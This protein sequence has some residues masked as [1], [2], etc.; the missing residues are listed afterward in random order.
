MSTG[1]RPSIFGRIVRRSKSLL[2]S[3]ENNRAQAGVSHSDPA[4]FER[5]VKRAFRVAGKYSNDS[6]IRQLV[7]ALAN[8]PNLLMGVGGDGLL[9]THSYALGTTLYLRGDYREARYFFLAAID[10]NK[11]HY[12][13]HMR[14][15][16]IC[17]RERNG[18]QANQFYQ[19]ALTFIQEHPEA[20][21]GLPTNEYIGE[22]KFKM[23]L[24][25]GDAGDL[26]SAHAS[27]QEAKRLAVENSST[28][29]DREGF[30]SWEDV[31]SRYP[32]PE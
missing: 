10:R 5:L 30:V 29:L 28:F 19:T 17:R 11:F 20:V 14:L 16:D 27:F 1:D 4:S 15:G 9:A 24:L 26:G 7:D 13:A 3:Q 8:S 2:N 32:I 23:G 12:T 22:I 31:F 18:E 21:K 6:T 25:R